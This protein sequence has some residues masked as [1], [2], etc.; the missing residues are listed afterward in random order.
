VVVKSKHQGDLLADLAETFT[1]LRKYNIKLNPQKCTFGIPSG[2]PLGYV[3]LKRGIEANPKKIDAIMRLRNPDCLL[4]VQKLVGWVAAL[5]RFIPKLGEKAMH[6][7]RLLPKTPMFEWTEEVDTTFTSLKKVLAGPTLLA[8]PEAKEPMLMYIVVTNRV[9]STV[10]V[11]ER[12]EE[13]REYPI[14][15]PVYYLSEVVTESK[16]RYP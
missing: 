3:V 15:Q 16:E 4:D 5:S 13:G 8:T 10:M 12:P 6:L 7:Y 14:Q 11:V 1:N 9:V 2:Q